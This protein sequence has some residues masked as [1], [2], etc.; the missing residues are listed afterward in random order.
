MKKVLL[1]ICL[2]L[3][4][5]VL[6]GCSQTENRRSAPVSTT[7]PASSIADSQ[8]Q[9]SAE[10]VPEAESATSLTVNFGDQGAPFT[11]HLYDNDTAAAIARHV[12]T[13]DWRL[14]IYHYDDYEN[15]E[16]MQYYDIPSRYE[17]PSNPENVTSE[18]AGE[19]YYSEPNRIVLFY[20][21]AQVSGEYTPVGYFD[22]TEDFV[23]AVE[24]NPVLEGW[25]NKIVRIAPGSN[26]PEIS[27]TSV[28][29]TE[30]QEESNMINLQIE[31]HNLTAELADNTSAQAFAELLQ[32]GPVT[33]QMH[34]YGNFEKIGPLPTSLPESNEQ[35]TT[36]PGDIIL[37]QGNSV[38][39]YYDVNTWNFTQLGKVQGVT[40]QELKDILGEGDV[41]ITFSVG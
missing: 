7:T 8:P 18:R 31:E 32:E 6:A 2:I 28:I 5:L 23:S 25:G 24:N 11:L 35:I 36:E 37:Y 13:A 26:E 15:W 1:F 40:Q 22:A 16:V 27:Q 20:G 17:I 41:E 12:G 19:V 10:S 39:V 33:V 30:E 38:T 3:C 14:P 29:T 34:D 21:D 9:T 4:T